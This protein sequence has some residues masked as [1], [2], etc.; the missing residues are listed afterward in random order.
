MSGG[1]VV[2]VL[3]DHFSGRTQWAPLLGSLIPAGRRN[4]MCEV[5][6]PP[7]SSQPFPL[8]YSEEVGLYIISID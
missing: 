7:L 8:L 5:K 2:V 6:E 1:V 4:I 3:V